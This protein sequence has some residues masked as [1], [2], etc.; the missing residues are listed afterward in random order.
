MYPNENVPPVLPIEAGVGSACFTV[1]PPGIDIPKSMVA[2]V[3]GGA[4]AG[5]TTGAGD[6]ATGGAGDAMG[7]DAALI[8]GGVDVLAAEVKELGGGI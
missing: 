2:G 6:G 8:V 1:Q 3:G 5:N 7:E 4:A